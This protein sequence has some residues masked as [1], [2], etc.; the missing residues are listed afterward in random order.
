MEDKTFS[1]WVCQTV[2]QVACRS[3]GVSILENFQNPSRQDVGKSA[4]A[5][6]TLN[7]GTRHS[8]GMLFHLNC[9]MI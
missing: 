3:C 2:A 7:R 6:P 5:D 8:P 1:Q 9:S 4:L